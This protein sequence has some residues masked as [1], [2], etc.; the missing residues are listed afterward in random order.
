MAI[1]KPTYRGVESSYFR[2]D[3]HLRGRRYQGSTRL[4]DRRK[5]ERFVDDLRLKIQLGQVDQNGKPLQTIAVPTLRDF[6]IRF[7]QSIETRCAEHPSTV[8]FYRNK[9]KYLLMFTPL[10]DARL[11]RID[12]SLIDNFIQHRRK[13]VGP[14]SVNR[15]LATLRRALRLAYTW[16]IIDRVPRI[17]MLSGELICDFVLTGEQEQAYLKIA[18]QPLHDIAILLL[19]EGLRRS[20]ALALQWPDISLVPTTGMPFGRLCVRKGK[21][22]NAKRILPMTSRV[23]A[24]LSVRQDDA[25]SIFIF[26]DSTGSKPFPVRTLEEQHQIARDKLKLLA[27]VLHSFRHTCATR[28]GDAGMDAVAIMHFMGHG[29]LNIAQRY[30]HVT[31]NMVARAGAVLEARNQMLLTAGVPV[32]STKAEMETDKNH[33]QLAE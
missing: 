33:P 18:G 8:E 1:F 11:N 6:Q 30:V 17:Q 23:C 10:A 19:D 16:R 21:S 3:F 32:I 9:F 29:S 22:R 13:A 27:C 4:G 12:E 24:A 2:Y 5:A 26:P 31:E 20:E 14:A 25:Q 15:E 28:L 7:M